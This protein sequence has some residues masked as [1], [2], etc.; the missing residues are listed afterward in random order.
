MTTPPAARRPPTVP[1][2]A[3]VHVYTAVGAVLA[4]WMVVAAFEGRTTTV[5]WLFL[6]AMVIDGSDGLLARRLRVKEAI[7]GFDGALLDNIVDYLTYCFAP[8]LLLW[9]DGRL[10][11]GAVGAVL[12]SLPM[13]ASSYGFCRSDAKTED[14]F[15]LGFPSYWNILAFYVV[16]LELSPT[17]TG[18]LVAV[19]AV[20][21]F[22]PVKYV[23]PSRTENWW[24]T[25]MAATAAWFA[26]YAVITVQLPDPN[27][28]LVGLS[29]AYVAFYTVE[30]LMLTLRRRR[31]DPAS[32]SA[33][34]PAPSA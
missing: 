7:P 21:V 18:V 16:V 24:W 30:S 4:F 3:L 19:F 29:L 31:T 11:G 22:V 9:A 17:V 14:H 12:A 34:A 2:A 23:Y 8:M 5:L 13:L 33:A 6:V 10:P 32:S 28:V 25:N 26:A 20:L 27:V 15:F 1:A